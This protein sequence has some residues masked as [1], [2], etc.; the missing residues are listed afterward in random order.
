MS[1]LE[2]QCPEQTNMIAFGL[3]SQGGN[4]SVFSSTI[5][6]RQAHV[7][8]GMSAFKKGISWFFLCFFS[9]K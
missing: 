6:E 5:V 4:T 9:L 3:Q 7:F 8:S 2:H 1:L